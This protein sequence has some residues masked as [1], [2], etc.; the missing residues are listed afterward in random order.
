MGKF[1][2]LQIYDVADEFMG[3]EVSVSFDL[4]GATEV[5][6]GRMVGYTP[7]PDCDDGEDQSI[8]VEADELGGIVEVPFGSISE[9]REAV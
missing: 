2:P 3:R 7:F 9:I 8:E 4:D 6:A 5:R 1:E